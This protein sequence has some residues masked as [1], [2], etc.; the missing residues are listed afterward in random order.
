[1]RE[2]VSEELPVWTKVDDNNLE[3]QKRGYKQVGISSWRQLEGTMSLPLSLAG[4]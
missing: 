3:K 1:M 4:V 2:H